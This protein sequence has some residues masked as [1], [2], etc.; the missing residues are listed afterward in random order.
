MEYQVKLD[1]FEGPLDLLLHLI[2]KNKLNIYDIPI[3]LITQ[4]YLDYLDLMR[5]LNIEVA[6]EFLVMAATLTYIKSKTLLPQPEEEDEEDPR[7]ELMRPLLELI[8]IQKAARE[9]ESRAV[10]DRDV[11]SRSFVP[12]EMME[13]VPEPEP[14]ISASIFDLIDA[15]KKLME[16]ETVEN[17][18]DVT[19]SRISISQ[20]IDQILNLLRPGQPVFFEDLFTSRI[21]SEMILTFLAI[22]EIV[23][24]GL[25]SVIQIA[26]QQIRIHLKEA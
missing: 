11:F 24:L 6:G 17:F 5:T 21:R 8:E 7:E 19:L 1:V 18:M 9:L 12:E 2:I 14:V 25:V 26:D 15:F 23:R 10:L 13:T 16:K 4:Q 20:K 22:L 3:A